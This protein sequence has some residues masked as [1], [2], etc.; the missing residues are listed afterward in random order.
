MRLYILSE[1]DDFQ[2]IGDTLF[3]RILSNFNWKF[4]R[5]YKR[6]YKRSSESCLND[7][8]YIT[9]FFPFVLMF[10]FVGKYRR[11]A[12]IKLILS[13][14]AVR[15]AP[16]GGMYRVFSESASIAKRSSNAITIKK[17]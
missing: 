7:V 17:L 12:H 4:S 16:T 8:T 9:W 15:V 2:I 11:R 14:I 1:N 13:I 10:I 3:I 6:T 5:T